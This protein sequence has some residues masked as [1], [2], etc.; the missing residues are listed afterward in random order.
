MFQCFG[1]PQI[2]NQSQLYAQMTIGLDEL[3]RNRAA[4]TFLCD[5]DERTGV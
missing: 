5:N 3:S 1:Y 4:L 2:I